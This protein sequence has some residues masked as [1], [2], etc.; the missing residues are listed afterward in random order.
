M[1]LGSCAAV[2]G[3]QAAEPQYPAQ[4]WLSPGIYSYHFDRDE[5]LRENNTGLGMEILVARDHALM[6]GTFINSEGARTRYGAYQWRAL[7][8]R[9]AGVSV[10]AGVAVGVFDGYPR[11][12]DGGSFV[13]AVPLLGIEG[14]RLGA[15][16]TI[17]PTLTGRLHGAVAVQVKLRVW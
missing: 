3:A 12:R 14:S 7:H 17:V 1:L 5:N 15:N 16:L 10:S 6:A 13:G 2:C 4:V 8:W 11:M 9:P